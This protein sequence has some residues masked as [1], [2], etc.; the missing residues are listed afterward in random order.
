MIRKNICI[1]WRDQDLFLGAE[2]LPL[3]FKRITTWKILFYLHVESLDHGYLVLNTALYKRCPYEFTN[4]R[5]PNLRVTTVLSPNYQRLPPL[6]LISRSVW[7]WVAE[8]ITGNVVVARRWRE[9][10]SKVTQRS[11]EGMSV[12]L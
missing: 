5:S 7:T 8:V 1:Q 12:N 3:P 10:H 2:I 4:I 6:Q 9:G 11:G